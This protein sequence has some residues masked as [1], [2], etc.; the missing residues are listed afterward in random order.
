MLVNLSQQFFTPV[1]PIY[2]KNSNSP[3]IPCSHIT[4]IGQFMFSPVHWTSSKQSD[5]YIK[6][7]STLSG[8]SLSKIILLQL[9][10]LCTSAVKQYYAKNNNSPFMCHLFPTHQSALKPKN[11][12][13]SSN[14]SL[15]NFLL[16]TA[17]RQKLYHQDF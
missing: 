16:W 11:V 14:L 9:Y 2:T 4:A 10:I 8:V 3:I 13:R 5:P 17:L 15:V 7:F 12:P 6:M 1:K